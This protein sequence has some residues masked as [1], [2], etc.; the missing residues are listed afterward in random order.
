MRVIGS[1]SDDPMFDIAQLEKEL[2]F[3]FSGSFREILV[4]FGGAVIFDNEVRFKPIQETTLEDSSGKHGLEIIYGI[5]GDQNGIKEKNDT[6]REQLSDR[7]IAIGEAA[8]GNLICLE[9]LSGRVFFWH[10]EATANEKSL[11]LVAEN[12]E[13]FLASLDVSVEADMADETKIVSSESFLNFWKLKPCSA[14]ELQSGVTRA[15]KGSISID[16]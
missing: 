4:N 1:S 3:S 14:G 13:E 7:F 6:Y 12:M 8:G 2:N 9:R 16:F 10:H 5:A 11:F 15:I